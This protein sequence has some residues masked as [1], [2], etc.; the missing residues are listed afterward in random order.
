MLINKE[1]ELEGFK[2]TNLFE[3]YIESWFLLHKL[4]SVLCR[5]LKMDR[6]ICKEVKFEVQ[7]CLSTYYNKSSYETRI[8]T[9]RSLAAIYP[10]KVRLCLI[11]DLLR[12][13]TNFK[14]LSAFCKLRNNGTLTF[15]NAPFCLLLIPSSLNLND[16]YSSLTSAVEVHSY[17]FIQCALRTSKKA[18][19][20]E[21]D[22]EEI[23]RLVSFLL[24]TLLEVRK[25]LS[26]PYTPA[27]LP[28]NYKFCGRGGASGLRCT[29]CL[30]AFSLS[31]PRLIPL[32]VENMEKLSTSGRIPDNCKMHLDLITQ[33]CFYTN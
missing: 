30:T 25:R 31:L 3:I 32:Y 4:L 27:M 11:L 18:L 12:T 8:F 7:T 26:S 20:P 19:F 9:L 33:S 14:N 21:S 29:K 24:M 10:V 28:D 5:A 23:V 15:C 16:I 2:E 22:C 13:R 6:Y 17:E 1:L